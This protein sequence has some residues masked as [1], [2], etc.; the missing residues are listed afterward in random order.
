MGVVF[1]SLV[2]SLFIFTP[3]DYCFIFSFCH[4]VGVS[5]IEF[6]ADVVLV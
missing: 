2:Q 5:H 1:M 3:P 4:S 6:H